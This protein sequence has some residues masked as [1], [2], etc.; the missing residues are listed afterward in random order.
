MH[1]NEKM[2]A[3]ETI[4]GKR[5]GRIKKNSGGGEFKHCTFDILKHLL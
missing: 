4:P 2:I 1:E 3:V 5:G